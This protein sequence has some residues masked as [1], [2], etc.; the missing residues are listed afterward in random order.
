MKISTCRFTLALF[1][2]ALSSTIAFAHEGHDHA[3][4]TSE[5]GTL[6]PAKNASPEWLAKAKAAYPTESC[7][8]SDDKLAGDM[9]GPMDYVYKQ[10][11]KPDRL[12]RFCC[13]DCVKDFNKDPD[14]YLGEIDK[15][16][17]SKNGTAKK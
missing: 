15:A 7:V 4:T 5:H 3:A 11:G 2:S 1:F 9:G 14:K 17:A 13:N 10:D 12:V 8:V 16:A 6:V